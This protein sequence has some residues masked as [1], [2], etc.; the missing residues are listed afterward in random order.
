MVAALQAFP[1]QVGAPLGQV[2]LS[3]AYQE[4][5]FTPTNRITAGV[6][7]VAVDPATGNAVDFLVSLDAAGTTP[8]QV[9]TGGS[10]TIP[11]GPGVFSVWVKASATTPAGAVCFA[12]CNA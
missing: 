6:Q 2:T 3:G 4:L 1:Q 7:L 10:Y 5:Q 9:P 8:E 11:V 12:A